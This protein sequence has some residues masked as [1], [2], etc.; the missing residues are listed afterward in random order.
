MLDFL[1]VP[2]NLKDY[3]YAIGGIT[4]SKFQLP[5]NRY[6]YVL[7]ILGAELDS[8]VLGVNDKGKPGLLFIKLGDNK[9]NN[10]TT[11]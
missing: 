10:K 11:F 6:G 4:L 2:W 7:K 9:K 8:I 1:A 5:S 3:L